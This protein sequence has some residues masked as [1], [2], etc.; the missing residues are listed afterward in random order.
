MNRSGYVIIKHHLTN[1]TT[2][3]AISNTPVYTQEM[4]DQIV[5]NYYPS[6]KETKSDQKSFLKMLIMK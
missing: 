2:G 5:E 1:P 3:Q 4:L 6:K